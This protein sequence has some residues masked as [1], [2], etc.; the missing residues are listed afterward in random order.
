MFYIIGIGFVK[1][2]GLAL[3]IE[4]CDLVS[5]GSYVASR[6]LQVKAQTTKQI[7]HQDTHCNKYVYVCVCV[8]I[9][10]Y[11]RPLVNKKR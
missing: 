2:I 11:I 10:I 7:D 3:G 9:Y 6:N 1:P 5:E 4:A 8:Y